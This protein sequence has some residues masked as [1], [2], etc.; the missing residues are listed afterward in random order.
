MATVILTWQRYGTSKDTQQIEVQVVGHSDVE[1]L[2]KASPDGDLDW[3][4]AGAALA[5]P[6]GMSPSKW[7]DILAVLA[8]LWLDRGKNSGAEA[9]DY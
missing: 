7:A 3:H 9:F 2:I 1:F 4:G 5:R 6:I 8:G